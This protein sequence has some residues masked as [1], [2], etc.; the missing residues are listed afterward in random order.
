MDPITKDN[1]DRSHIWTQEEIIECGLCINEN[2]EEE[3]DF[4]RDE[5]NDIISVGAQDEYDVDPDILVDDTNDFDHDNCLPFINEEKEEN[6]EP[7]QEPAQEPTVEPAQDPILEPAQ[8]VIQHPIQEPD[9]IQEPESDI[10]LPFNIEKKEEKE[11]KDEDEEKCEPSSNVVVNRLALD[12][13]IIEESAPF[14]EDRLSLSN[15]EKEENPEKSGSTEATETVPVEP[16]VDE[17]LAIVVP[18]IIDNEANERSAAPAPAHSNDRVEV[19]RPESYIIDAP[20]ERRFKWKTWFQ[21]LW[22]WS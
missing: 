19:S 3:P 8:E 13:S 18:T 21:S 1:H 22:F 10:V 16:I 17:P 5:V 11:E 6:V 15:E 12:E 20:P 2:E 14:N 4:E 7:V 9:P